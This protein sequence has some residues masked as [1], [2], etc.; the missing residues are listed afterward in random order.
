MIENLNM[1]I[2]DIDLCRDSRQQTDKIKSLDYNSRFKKFRLFYNSVA[3]DLTSKTVRAYIIKSDGKEIFNNLTIED[4][5]I[6]VFEF[7]TQATIVSGLHKME[8]VVYD[9]DS[10]L[11]SFMFM[12]EVIKSLRTDNSIESQNEY[13]SLQIGLKNL[14]IWNRESKV[15]YEKWSADFLNLYED[16]DFTMNELHD[17]WDKTLQE[18]YNNLNNEYAPELVKIKDKMDRGENVSAGQI[19]G[20]ITENQISDSL[21]AMI[22]GSAPVSADVADKSINSNKL[23]RHSIDVNE[24]SFLVSGKN[25]YNKYKRTINKTI[26]GSIPSTASIQDS[27]SYDISD[28]IYVKKGFN[29]ISQPG[30]RNLYLY[31]VSGECIEVVATNLKATETYSFVASE[32]GYI[33]ATLFKTSSDTWQFEQSEAPTRYEEYKRYLDTELQENINIKKKQVTDFNVESDDCNFLEVAKNKLNLA[34]FLNGKLITKNNEIVDNAGYNAYMIELEPGTYTVSNRTRNIFQFDSNLTGTGLI[35]T[36]SNATL[37]TPFTFTIEV[38]SWIG[39]NF[40]ADAVNMQLEEGDTPTGFEPYGY[41]MNR[42]NFTKE[43]IDKIKEEVAES[44]PNIGDLKVLKENNKFTIVT[45]LNNKESIKYETEIED[46]RNK[47]FNFVNTYLL[48]NNKEVY[49]HNQG[50]D[51]TPI[52]TFYTV[53]ANHG[54]PCFSIPSNK[55]T[56]ADIGSIWTDGV[57]DYVLA[58]IENNKCIFLYPY[59]E[60]SQGIVSF[61]NVAPIKDLE[62]KLNA[63]NTNTLAIANLEVEQFYCSVN[64]HSYVIK[65]DNKDLL[66]GVNTGNELDITEK[67][68]I[69]CYKSL[70]EHLKSNVGKELVGDNLDEID[71]VVELAINYK[72]KDNALVLINHSLKILKKVTLGNCGFLQSVRLQPNT[73]HYMPNVKSKGKWDFSKL[74]NINS[75]KDNL[76]FTLSDCINPKYPLNR[77]VQ[78]R[79]CLDNNKVGFTAGYLPDV[80]SGSNVERLKNTILWDFRST[81]K[82]YPIG[83]SG[84]TLE[85]GAYLTFSMY[86][87]YISTSD[88]GEGETNKTYIETG[89]SLYVFIDIHKD[90]LVDNL[91]VPIKYIDKNIEVLEQNEGFELVSNRVDVRGVNYNIKN[92][93]GYAVL[94][95]K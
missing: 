40:F 33:R 95:I 72:F 15:L 23:A 30:A 51:I 35:N 50:D 45:K 91:E 25:L 55:Q 52:R 24:A 41:S 66:E 76:K 58:K 11:S 36:L 20:G 87:K 6:A 3:L 77:Y 46:V 49:I 17:G 32:T 5:N 61:K 18:K 44:N 54:Y 7:T 22:A 57:T 82:S 90:A 21:K 79:N 70:Q 9:A 2:V 67:Y 12:Y 43:Q 94:K 88:L 31:N 92:N 13:T 65:L 19:T 16:K 63:T 4:G 83:Y 89:D 59:I 27:S 39:I 10:E 8:L 85:P 93:Y 84:G 73:E 60:D 48:K 69:L 68:N 78:H 53:G 64:R 14:E 38:K 86:R 28:Y 42:L 74:T 47:C 29:N 81:K 37:D 56:S 75:Y 80:G 34:K 71:G 1:Q 62:A 26:T